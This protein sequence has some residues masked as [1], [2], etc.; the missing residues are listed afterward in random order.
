[1]QE[2]FLSLIPSKG[3][4]VVMSIGAA[5]GAA[6]SFLFGEWGEGMQWLFLFVCLDYLTGSLAAW[7]AGRYSSD[8]GLRG[9]ARKLVVFLIVALAHGIDT[10]AV[11]LGLPFALRD[12]MICALGLNEVVSLIENIDRLGYGDLIPG[13]VRRGL[14]SLQKRAVKE[15]EEAGQHPQRMD[16]PSPPV[17]QDGDG[18]GA[19]KNL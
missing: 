8:A 16:P 10:M 15:I 7:I 12:V 3:Q 9:I 4:A 19:E 13:F 18:N 11:G 5:L 14:R 6:A 2:F 17:F 1:M